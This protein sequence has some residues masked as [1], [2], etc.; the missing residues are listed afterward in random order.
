MCGVICGFLKGTGKVAC[1]C[2]ECAVTLLLGILCT[3]IIV[4]LI[5]GLIVYFTVFHNKGSDKKVVEEM[6]TAAPLTFRD[7]F[8]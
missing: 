2:L 3:V 1:C 7:F 6:I 5:I 4:V 8:Q